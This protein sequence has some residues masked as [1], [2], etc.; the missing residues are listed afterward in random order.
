MLNEE[1]THPSHDPDSQIAKIKDG[2]TH[3]AH[4]VEHAVD[5]G[6]GAVVDV[7]LQE[8]GDREAV[9]ETAVTSAEQMEA[10]LPE[11]SGVAEMVGDKGYH[12]NETLVGL[13]AVGVRSYISEPDRSK[14]SW[15][16]RIRGRTSSTGW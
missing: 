5:L 4:K 1:W 8:K 12:S 3:M 13:A 11:G 2:S 15:E 9:V 14:R 16:D 7:T 6:T 10:A